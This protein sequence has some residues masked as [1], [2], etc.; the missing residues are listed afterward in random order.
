MKFPIFS[1][2]KIL[3]YFISF[4]LFCFGRQYSFSYLSSDLKLSAIFFSSAQLAVW[5]NCTFGPPT[6]FCLGVR[7]PDASRHLWPPRP[8]HRSLLCF[9]PPIP[10][11]RLTSSSSP[12][13]T[14][15]PHLLPFPISISR[16]RRHW[17]STVTTSLLMIARLLPP[18]GSIKGA[19]GAPPLSTAPTLAPISPHRS[20]T[21]RLYW[22][23]SW[24]HLRSS[25]SKQ[26]HWWEPQW[27][28]L[29]LSLSFSLRAITMTSWAQDGCAT[30]WSIDPIHDFSY[31]ETIMRNPKNAKIEGIWFFNKSRNNS[32]LFPN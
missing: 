29:S 10:S 32:Y 20:T 31:T 8:S 11:S 18:Y 12:Q 2:P 26:C 23:P 28:P 13:K 5:P 27:P 14:A 30:T 9:L 1:S 22:A 7:H 25:A 15:A 17:S 16:N 24:S 19:M 21:S 6:Q 3:P 4:F